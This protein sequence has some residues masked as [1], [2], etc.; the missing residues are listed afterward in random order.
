M[1]RTYVHDNRKLKKFSLCLKSKGQNTVVR[2]GG[3]ELPTTT[4]PQLVRGTSG[5]DFPGILDSR[6]TGIF[7]E[8]SS[9]P[10]NFPGILRAL[11]G[12]N[13]KG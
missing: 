2:R 6:E 5:V 7:P 3:Q 11:D 8:F 9:F 1:Y 12:Q 13:F 10:G 4:P